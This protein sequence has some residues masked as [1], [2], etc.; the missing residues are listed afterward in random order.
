MTGCLGIKEYSESVVWDNMNTWICA[1]SLLPSWG[2]A[3][4]SAVCLLKESVL[5]ILSVL[6][7][8]DS[9]LFPATE[10][11]LSFPSTQLFSFLK[12]ALPESCRFTCGQWCWIPW[13]WYAQPAA[14]TGAVLYFLL[15]ALISAHGVW[16]V[17]LSPWTEH[18]ALV[19]PL[20]LW[21]D[22]TDPDCEYVKQWKTVMRSQLCPQ[23]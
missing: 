2:L 18:F 1:R 3:P 16:R 11:S 10:I 19:S 7:L 4:G 22:G 15:P 13:F 5:F 21:A 6:L 12:I 9:F 17:S 23:G 14:S 8:I 20:C